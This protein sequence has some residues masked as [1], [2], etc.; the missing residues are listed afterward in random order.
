MMEE[1]KTVVYIGGPM[2]NYPEHN[3]PLFRAVGTI[4][5]AMGFEVL[6]P[7]RPDQEG[8]E[9]RPRAELMK[10]DVQ[11]VSRSKVIVLLDGWEK[12]DGACLEVA[13]ARDTGMQ[14]LQLSLT[15]VDLDSTL[16]GRVTV[17]DKDLVRLRFSSCGGEDNINSKMKLLYLIES[18]PVE[19]SKLN[20][21]REDATST[22]HSS[23]RPNNSAQSGCSRSFKDM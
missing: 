20:E 7:S 10:E 12:S 21:A 3:Y 22:I 9:K 18:A 5:K 13:N 6:D 14:V 4:L 11:M 17:M 16:A 8:S 1:K 19:Q 23:S 2:S 15:P